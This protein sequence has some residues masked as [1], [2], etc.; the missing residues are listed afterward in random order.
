LTFSNVTTPFLPFWGVILK[1]ALPALL[2]KN[3]AVLF[4]FQVPQ[5]KTALGGIEL[6]VSS[7]FML[8][9]ST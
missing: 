1:T 6:V 3:L 2:K 4:I 8:R 7:I 9:N 5:D